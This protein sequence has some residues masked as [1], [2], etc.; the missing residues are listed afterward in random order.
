MR[1]AQ[2]RN[3]TTDTRIF[4]SLRDRFFSVKHQV[5]STESECAKKCAMKFFQF[6]LHLV[7][8]PI[9]LY[10]VSLCKAFEHVP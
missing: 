3:R 7:G 9:R 8:N 6:S 1:G 5:T 4:S 2:G 10:L